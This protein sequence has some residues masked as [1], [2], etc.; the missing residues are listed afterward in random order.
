[1]QASA[2]PL[3]PLYCGKRPGNLLPGLGCFLDTGYQVCRER[4]WHRQGVEVGD[5]ERHHDKG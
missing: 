3:K 2:G 4:S 1:M 5:K